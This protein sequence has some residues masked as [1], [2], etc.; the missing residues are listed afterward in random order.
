MYRS[1]SLYMAKVHK[2]EWQDAA[3]CFR[4]KNGCSRNWVSP[5]TPVRLRILSCVR[6]LRQGLRLPTR[7][8]SVKERF[9]DHKNL[10]SCSRSMEV[11]SGR[12]KAC[13]YRLISCGL[14][15]RI[16]FLPSNPRLVNLLA[17]KACMAHLTSTCYSN[18][19][20]DLISLQV[21]TI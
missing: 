4:D 19:A 1:S 2:Y 16:I 21:S 7:S 9:R 20:P 3:H 6:C 5:I 8:A 18:L 17:Q 11:Q 10:K 13:Q 15:C 12:V 14:A